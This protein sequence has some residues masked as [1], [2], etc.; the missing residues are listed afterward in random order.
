MSPPERRLLWGMLP[1]QR[2]GR[3]MHWLSLM[4]HT[5]VTGYGAEQQDG[6]EVLPAR[7]RQPTHRFVAAGSL[8]WYRDL[9]RVP[10]RFDWYASLEFCAL[11]TGQVVRRARRTGARSAVLVWGNDPANPLYRLPP[12]RQAVARSRDADLFLCLIEA[13]RQH[14]LALGLDAERCAVVHPG[15]DTALFT[16]PAEPVADAVAVFAS[17]LAP[18]K[19]IDRVLDAFDLVRARLP[20]ARLLVLGRGPLEHLVRA[21]EARTAGAVRY[22]GVRPLTGVA[23]VLRTAAVFVT[24]P[25]PTRVWNEQFGMAYLEAMASGLAVVTTACGSNSEAVPPP[26]ALVPDDVE[27]VAAALT[28]VLGDPQARA[29]VARANRAHVLE[30]HELLRQCRRMGDA[31]TAAEARG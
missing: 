7:F 30:H 29:A 6:V 13:A 17:P 20:E 27:A 10:P 21:A 16:P 2:P 23:E 31:F 11:V 19:G 28:D 15:V 8:A 1:D 22:L 25:R 12:Y 4:P 9:D 3:E 24:A 14:C 26:N 5:R 18:N